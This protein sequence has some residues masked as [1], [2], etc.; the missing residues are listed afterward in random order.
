[1]DIIL[2]N[3]QDS[4]QLDEENLKKKISKLIK[5]L[6][7]STDEISFHFVDKEKITDLHGEFFNDPTPTDCITFPLES[8]EI[9]H[10]ILG[11]VFVCTDV[12]IEYAKEHKINPQDEVLLYVIH[13]LFFC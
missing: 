11:E 1:M 3:E 5:K 12:A 9:G 10:H 7:I 2:Y 4:L 8:D 13:G 6:Q